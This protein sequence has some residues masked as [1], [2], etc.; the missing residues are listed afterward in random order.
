MSETCSH[1][2]MPF[3][4]T[5]DNTSRERREGFASF[6]FDDILIFLLHEV[7]FSFLLV[8]FLRLLLL[9]WRSLGFVFWMFSAREDETGTRF[10]LGKTLSWWRSPLT[11][12]IYSFWAIG[13][14]RL[15][16]WLEHD[17]ANSSPLPFPI[18]GLER[19]LISCSWCSVPSVAGFLTLMKPTRWCIISQLA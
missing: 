17:T 14:A 16:K 9:C 1:S 11:C 15:S 5:W 4:E 13:C 12:S 2:G 7:L 3:S 18:S 8:T 10:S 19:T 6:L